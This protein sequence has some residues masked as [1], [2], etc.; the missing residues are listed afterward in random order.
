MTLRIHAAGPSI[1]RLKSGLAGD[2]AVNRHL[3]PSVRG[4]GLAGAAEAVIGRA[5]PAAAR[6][7]QMLEFGLLAVVLAIAGSVIWGVI[8]LAFPRG[9]ATLHDLSAGRSE[10]ATAG[11][12]PLRL[13]DASAVDFEG[14]I[15]AINRNVQARASSELAWSR[16]R[17]GRVLH[18]QDGIQT[19]TGASAVVRVKRQGDIAIGE[20]SLVVFE[21]GTAD[22]FLATRRVV[23]AIDHGEITASLMARS[24]A[25][26]LGIRLPNGAIRLQ[27]ES[28][29]TT[30]DFHLTVRQDH[31]AEVVILKGQAQVRAGGATRKLGTGEAMR[32]SADGQ[33]VETQPLPSVPELLE[34]ADAALLVYRKERPT[35]VF[36]WQSRAMAD[37]YRFVLADDREFLHPLVDER[38]TA[39]SYTAARLGTGEYYWKVS[40]RNGWLDSAPSSIAALRVERDIDARIRETLAELSR[41]SA[42]AARLTD[43]A[44]GMLVFPSVIKGGIVIGGEYGEGAL[45]SKG[46]TVG[47]YTLKSASLG[48]QLGGQTRRVVLL[49]MTS[50]AY[51]TF[52]RS[53]GW[54]VGVD[55]SVAVA[56]VGAA[57]TIDTASSSQPIIAFVFSG[58][59]LMYNLTL[60]GSKISRLPDE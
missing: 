42:D 48:L 5:H 45:L 54:K 50:D 39:N 30:A 55:G 11:T 15:A 40:S 58:K 38:V 43:Q 20:N 27:A 47:Y 36:R 46:R 8:Q 22:P 49:F 57:K 24:G 1:H 12:T 41:Q 35:I 25:D 26:A 17:V 31:S 14:V 44:E 52:R 3:L 56:A 9:T 29:G 51:G 18:T 37:D 6:D 13:A 23:A 2:V 21:T 34:P 7:R 59:G 19:L 4:T 10:Q 60:E 53:S 33:S 28:P 16:A 32:I